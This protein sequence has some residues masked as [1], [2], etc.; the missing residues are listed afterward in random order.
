MR[1][2]PYLDIF[3][4]PSVLIHTDATLVAAGG[5]CKE[6]HFHTCFPAVIAR[7][8]YIIAHLELLAFIVVLKAWP[9]L[10]ANTKFVE[11]LDNMIAVS[12]TNS[13]IPGTHLSMQA[14][15]KLLTF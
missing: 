5:V 1:Q 9:H 13:G 15:V 8:A 11:H 2:S 7:K 4:E 3:F 6:H 12:A 10:I 14:H